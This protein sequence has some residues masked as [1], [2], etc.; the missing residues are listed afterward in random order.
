MLRFVFPLIV[1]TG[2]MTA[3]AC[4]GSDPVA[5]EANNAAATPAQENAI[6]PEVNADSASGSSEV[7]TPPDSRTIPA[8][9]HG[10]WGLTPADCTSTRGDAKGLL[11]VSADQ[12]KFYESVGKPAGEL[13]ISPDSASGDFAFTG[14]GMTWKKYQ[15]LEL[16]NGK[17]VRTE[18]SPMA[19]FT[20]A[21]CT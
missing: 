16:Q 20:Y 9:L 7:A 18:S 2:V 1:L 4:S 19:S 15:A 3:G 6:V 13:E 14:E 11:V 17:L 21:R 5:D 8:F 10:R 12:M